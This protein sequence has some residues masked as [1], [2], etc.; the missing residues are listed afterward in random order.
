MTDTRAAAIE[1]IEARGHFQ[2]Q[3]LRYVAVNGVFVALWAL[4]GG[5]FFW[6]AFTVIG[7][8]LHLA[9]C[10]IRVS[11]G[12]ITTEAIEREMQRPA[13]GGRR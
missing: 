9:I 4:G 12:P 5:G 2:D 8:G 3:I 11:P 7:W 10:M 6:P 13:M 1:R